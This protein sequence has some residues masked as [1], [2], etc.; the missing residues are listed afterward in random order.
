MAPGKTSRQVVFLLGNNLYI[1]SSITNISRNAK[2]YPAVRIK[3]SVK[4][5]GKRDTNDRKNEAPIEISM[6]R[7]PPIARPSSKGLAIQKGRK[8]VI[9]QARLT[10]S[11]KVP[12]RAGSQV[13]RTDIWH[14]PSQLS[15]PCHLLCGKRHGAFNVHRRRRERARRRRNQDSQGIPP[16]APARHRRRA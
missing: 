8:V 9:P 14:P 10:A 6:S 15:A 11:S 7:P 12:F 4:G 16:E 13:R 3:K 2:M 1:I 5:G